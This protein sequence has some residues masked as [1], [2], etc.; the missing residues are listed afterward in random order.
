[1]LT[2]YKR[3]WKNS[4]LKLQIKH[5]HLVFERQLTDLYEFILYHASKQ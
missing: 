3:M 1:M 5:S 4:V 2:L